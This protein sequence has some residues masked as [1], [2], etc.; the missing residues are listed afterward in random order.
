MCN[1]LIQDIH[2]KW[3]SEWEVISQSRVRESKLA[4]RDRRQRDDTEVVE[5]DSRGLEQHVTENW[6]ASRDYTTAT[7]ILKSSME[8]H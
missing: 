7:I 3:C 2:H 8:D 6:A 4:T 1:L 5:I